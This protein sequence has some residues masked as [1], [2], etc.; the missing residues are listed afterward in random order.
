MRTGGHSLS[1]KL[2]ILKKSE[3][4]FAGYGLEIP[5]GKNENGEKLELYSSYFHLDVKD[6]WVMVFRY[7]PEDLTE[8]Q[9][10]RF[11]RYSHPR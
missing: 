1:L 9:R 2:V 3:I 6:K 8:A 11:S 5:E 10:R 4:V 7:M